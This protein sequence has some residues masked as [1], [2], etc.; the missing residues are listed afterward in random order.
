MAQLPAINYTGRDYSTIRALLISHIKARFPSDWQDLYASSIGMALLELTAYC[1]VGETKIPL[2]DG[3]E[4]EIKDLVGREPFWVY[5]ADEQS[6]NIVPALAEAK[7]TRQDAELVEVTLDN[8]KSVRCTPNHLWLMRDSTYKPACELQQGDSLM[9]LYRRQ[10]GRGYEQTKNPATG[11]WVGTHNLCAPGERSEI[12]HHLPADVIRLRQE[13]LSVPEISRQLSCSKDT[14]KARLAQAN[15]KIVSVRALQEREDVY[16]ISILEG[17]HN[18]GLSV[19]CF[20]HNCTDQLSYFLDYTANEGF[21]PTLQHR[22]SIVNLGKLV[23]Y[24]LRPASAAAVRVKATIGSV[25][26][27]DTILPSGTTVSATGDVTFRTVVDQRI[28]AGDLTALLTFVEG[29]DQADAFT[30]DGAAWQKFKLTVPEV[31][32]GSLVVRVAGV[33]WTEVES[34]IYSDGT[35]KVYAIDYDDDDYG[36]IQFGDGDCGALPPNGAAITVSYRVGGGLVG[37]VP[38]GAIDTAVTGWLDGVAPPQAIPMDLLNE[39]PGSGGLDRETLEHARR[40]IPPWVSANGRAVTRA[41]FNA[42]ANAFRDPVY[43]APAFVSCWLKQ[44]VPEYNMVCAAIWARDYAGAIVAPSAGLKAALYNYFMNN[45]QGAIRVICTDVEVVDGIIV[46]LDLSIEVQLMSDFAATEVSTNVA[47]AVRN[48]LDDYEPGDDFH[49]SRAYNAIQD[50]AGVAHGLINVMTASVKTESTVATGDGVATNFPFTPPITRYLTIIPGTVRID[51]GTLVVIDDGD[52]L[53]V[54]SVDPA[55][56]NTIDYETGAVDV[57]F[58]GAPALGETVNAEFRHLI[59]YQRGGQEAV[60][61]G[62][63]GE[64]EGSVKFPPIVPHDDILA[65]GGIAFTTGSQT[66]VDD[67]YGVL[68]GDVAPGTN[69]INYDTGAYKFTFA[70]VPAAGTKIYSTYRQLLRTPSEDVPLGPDQLLVPGT[71]AVTTIAAAT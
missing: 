10:S 39:E 4:A 35:A 49:L 32:D 55:G 2:L 64:V 46:Y 31:V 47:V 58:S 41:D 19:G 24:K 71:I 42:L 59:D 26:T 20:L 13:G 30:S 37:N 43:G 14:V 6:Q 34:L 1:V 53:L 5:A 60:M 45:G 61:D 69:Y 9:P 18:F 29:L 12:V 8:G 44:E 56:A 67:G 65:I 38:I 17:P 28:P 68:I 25:Q 36:Y 3:A 33:D 15:H 52:G 54:G 23:G 11:R 63:T 40:W 51:A 62:T 48:L 16:D 7:L 21:L 22:E 70:V 27:N 57:T 50:S 66:V